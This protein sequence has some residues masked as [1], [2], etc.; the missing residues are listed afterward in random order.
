MRDYVL[1]TLAVTTAFIDSAVTKLSKRALKSFGMALGLMVLSAAITACQTTP[2]QNVT[3]RNRYATAGDDDASFTATDPQKIAEV[4]TR[5][6]AEHIRDNQLDAAQ[7]QLEKAFAANKRYA[8]AYDMMGVLLQREGSRSNLEKADTFFKQAIEIEPDF[9]QARNN[10]GVYLSQMGRYQQ[11]IEQFKI[12]GA[13]LGY[14]GRIGALENLGR[15][16]LK[17]GDT[18]LASQ[19]FVRVLDSDRNNIIAHIELVDILINGKRTAQ[20]QNLYEEMKVL[21]GDDAYKVPR[22]LLQGATLAHVQNNLTLQEDLSRQLLANFPL[23]EEA[24]KLKGWLRHSEASW[25]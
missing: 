21:M 14:E 7:R 8:P 22:I 15:T 5:M 6:A 2:A 1:D 17:L 12:A 3:D 10:Y 24:Q 18:E 20:A 19:T 4:R 25:K 13:A 11:A 9:I 16:A 23:S